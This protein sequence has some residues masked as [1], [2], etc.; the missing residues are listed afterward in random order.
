[1]SPRRPVLQ[2]SPCH[3]SGAMPPTHDRLKADA[4]LSSVAGAIQKA[5]MTLFRPWKSAIIDYSLLGFLD[6]ILGVAAR[7][8]FY[9]LSFS[10]VAT[11]YTLLI[12]YVER[13]NKSALRWTVS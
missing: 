9:S 10:P 7:L 12:W 6:A 3:M 2:P 4:S 8:F 1:M 13:R 11:R 5:K